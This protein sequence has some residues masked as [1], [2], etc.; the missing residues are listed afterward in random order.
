MTKIDLNTGAKAASHE[1]CGGDE[2]RVEEGQQEVQLQVSPRP[3]NEAH[4]RKLQEILASI[5]MDI[6]VEE[7]T[8]AVIGI[9]WA[10]ITRVS[11][12]QL[13]LAMASM[14]CL[15]LSTL[16]SGFSVYR[17]T[18]SA[19]VTY[20]V[21]GAFVGYKAGR[22]RCYAHII[23]YT[24]TCIFQTLVYMSTMC[25]LVYTLYALDAQAEFYERTHR[26][27]SDTV[28]FLTLGEA[29]TLMGTVLT[30]VFGLIGCCRGLGR[31]LAEQEQAMMERLAAKQSAPTPAIA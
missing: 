13:T 1:E 3:D 29:L 31:L 26:R 22:G 25:W 27:I 7:E 24:G 28:L 10:Y 18:S 4:Q 23:A 20:L 12:C 6:G 17:F 15:T 21:F 19:W 5:G 30:G 9:D 2:Q 11:K 8:E 16:L 14:M